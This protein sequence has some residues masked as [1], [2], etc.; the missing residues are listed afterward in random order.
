M[1]CQTLQDRDSEGSR[2]MKFKVKKTTRLLETP[3]GPKRDILSINQVV[4]G[5]GKSDG[6]FIEVD[7]GDG[8][9]GWVRKADCDP[10]GAE[11]RPAIDV[12]NYVAACIN[13]ERTI[14]K[15]TTTPPW[16]VSAD[17]V[18]ARALV[19]TPLTSAGDLTNAGEKNPPSDA[20]G[21]LQV[22]SSE[23]EA[24]RAGTGQLGAVFRP[25]DF[26][27]AFMQIHGAAYRMNTDAK[28]ISNVKLQNGVGSDKDP[29]LPSLLDVFHAYLTNSPE[30]AVAILD[31]QATDADKS[32][33]IN[34]VLLGPL[35]QEQIDGLFAT[36]GQFM[37]T[38]A[39]PK[40]VAEFV[41]ATEPALGDAL[42]KAFDLI[43]ENAPEELPQLAKAEAPWF[44]IALQAEKEA[45]DQHDPDDKGTILDYFKA[46][47][48]R[49]LPNEILAWCGA[50][51]AHCMQA[52]GNPAATEI[53]K[54]AAA[55]ASWKG[56][57]DALTLQSDNIPVG[58]VVVLAP[59]EGTGTTGHVGFFVQL[60]DDGQRVELLGGNQG[61]KVQRSPFLKSRVAA[62]RWLGVPPATAAGEPDGPP[63]DTPISK[64]AIDL[65]VNAEVSSEAAYNRLY[66]KPT[67]PQGASGVTIG[68]GYDVGY[69]TPEKLEADWTGL[70]PPEMVDHLKQ[71]C[72]VKRSPAGPLA[73]QL[74]ADGVDVPFAAAMDVFLK[75]DIPL[76]VGRVEHALPPAKTLNED[77]LGALVS[78]AYNRGASFSK[79]GERYEE[80]NKIRECLASPATFAEIPDQF[81]SMK[82]LWPDMA[83]LRTRRDNEANLFQTGLGINNGLQ[84]A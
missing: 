62:V 77:C 4:T 6:D 47:D 18:I 82:R 75:R 84:Q 31:A 56:F 48:L 9:P 33:K 13:A 60:L 76:W 22:S 46:T 42:K 38:S 78:L 28:A 41:A 34:A 24:F 52:S 16:F 10:I 39:A 64:E 73:K 57:G 71:A 68:I 1:I 36:R 53:P 44:D 55:A 50:F 79:Q 83:G 5:T 12:G 67:W 37:G 8:K 17:F 32:K 70:I 80:M 69:T 40:T 66:H 7:A 19:E 2:A 45:I 14:N 15:L 43:K 30:A 23:W 72:G 49:P 25:G 74:A 65:I 81:R 3:A 59:S 27:D 58:A 63:S 61:H 21:P 20:V 51:A 29:F 11:Q 35:K 26:D 54:G